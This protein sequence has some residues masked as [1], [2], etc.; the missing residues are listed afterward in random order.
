MRRARAERV[1]QTLGGAHASVAARDDPNHLAARGKML[2]RPSELVAH[3][4]S[5]RA[6]NLRGVLAVRVWTIE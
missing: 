1:E 2:G 5:Q 4:W 3:L 6:A